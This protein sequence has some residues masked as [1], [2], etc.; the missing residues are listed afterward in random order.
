MMPTTSPCLT[1]NETSSS[2][3]MVLDCGLRIAD[4]GLPLPF[5]SAERRRRNGDLAPSE[6]TSRRALYLS[7]CPMRYCLLRPAQRMAISDIS[8]R[9]EVGSQKQI[10]NCSNHV[11]KLYFHA[12]EVVETADQK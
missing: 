3:Q 10:G 2:A 4:K 11:G 9:S 8:Q 7:C 1:S 6:S 5:L 12:E